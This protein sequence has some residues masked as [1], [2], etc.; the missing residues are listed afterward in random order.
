MILQDFLICGLIDIGEQDQRLEWLEAAADALAKGFLKSKRKLVNATL[1]ALD[2]GLPENEPVFDAV[3]AAVLTQWKALRAKYPDRP[4]QILRAVIFRALEINQGEE[5]AASIVWLVGGTFLPHARMGNE[6]PYIEKLITTLGNT[7]EEAAVARWMAAP[8]E[9]AVKIPALKLKA[10][11]SEVKPLNVKWMQDALGAAAGSGTVV[12]GYPNNTFQIYNYQQQWAQHFGTHG[13][14]AIVE[15]FNA[16]L[17][18]LLT[19]VAGTMTRFAS[20]LEEHGT[21][22]IAA[23]RDTLRQS[24]ENQSARE[25]RTAL[26]WWRQTLYSPSRR[27][28]YRGMAT[29][30]LVILTA[31]DLHEQVPPFSPQS[32]EFLLREVVREVS[33]ADAAIDGGQLLAGLRE[34][35]S[36]SGLADLDLLGASPDE[37][38]GRICLAS[39]IGEVL[40]GRASAS[41]MDARVGLP[42][43]QAL[44]LGEW[45]V[46]IFR[47]LQALRITVG[48]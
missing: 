45:A 35:A 7:A 9:K 27:R 47:D 44:P 26:L 41:D 22:L 14:K 42:A 4:R 31:F 2:G 23:V 13:G 43:T 29:G 24:T 38:T 28:G 34:T 3:E 17:Q 15:A 16:S 37:S 20:A 19:H 39:F 12:D 46:W 11:G 1:V 8:P 18:P 5:A 10:E 33:G 21:A 48:K 6:R 25:R 30:P 32:V 36:S 40:A